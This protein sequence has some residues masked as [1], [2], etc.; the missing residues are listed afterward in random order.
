MEGA[1]AFGRQGMENRMAAPPP[2]RRPRSSQGLSSCSSI[3]AVGPSALL[4]PRPPTS[5]HDGCACREGTRPPALST[6]AAGTA[7]KRPSCEGRPTFWMPCRLASLQT[8]AR[9]SD[10]PQID[11][12]VSFIR[13]MTGAALFFRPHPPG[14]TGCSQRGG[15]PRRQRWGSSRPG[16]P[17]PPARQRGPRAS[18]SSGRGRSRPASSRSSSPVGAPAASASSPARP[19]LAG[20]SGGYPRLDVQPPQA[21]LLYPDERQLVESL[22]TKLPGRW[23]VA[24]LGTSHVPKACQ[25]WDDAAA[26][27]SLTPAAAASLRSPQIKYKRARSVPKAPP[28]SS[29]VRGGGVAARAGRRPARPESKPRG[30]HKVISLADMVLETGLVAVTLGESPQAAGG[31]AAAMGLAAAVRQPEWYSR[32]HPAEYIP[33]ELLRAE[34]NP[35][36]AMQQPAAPSDCLA[37]FSVGETLLLAAP[38]GPNREAVSLA[39]ISLEDL[40]HHRGQQ[41]RPSAS[42]PC[43]CS[44]PLGRGAGSQLTLPLLLCPGFVPAADRGRACSGAAACAQPPRSPLRRGGGAGGPLGQRPAHPRGALPVWSHLPAGRGSRGR[45]R[46][47]RGQR[48]AVGAGARLPR[49]HGCAHRAPGLGA[50]PSAEG[51]AAL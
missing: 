47:R 10:A 48:A 24:R 43:C 15:R 34:L 51:P 17:G 25:A 45:R 30:A 33:H 5:H 21:H 11:D 2:P 14:L 8:P 50:A 38:A 22:S 12:P 23:A 37:A 3:A 6:G 28:R 31:G 26:G 9:A 29:G 40:H 41:V 27:S 42:R 35:L 32:Q 46:G 4:P 44:L 16:R 49:R 13:D 18:G 1:Q 39:A 19:W 20:I 7:T 36:Q